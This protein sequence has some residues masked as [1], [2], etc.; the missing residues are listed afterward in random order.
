[1]VTLNLIKEIVAK[2]GSKAELI[3]KL[4]ELSGKVFQFKLEGE[5]PFYVVIKDDGTLFLHE[6]E[7]G[8]PTATLL[9]RDDI[10]AAIIQ[11]RMSGVQA[12]FRGLLKIQGDVMAIRKFADIMRS[13]RE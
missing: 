8:T 2:A 7:Y 11:G 3:V 6:G 10:M 5:V 12:F 13:T 9:A 4:R 1:M